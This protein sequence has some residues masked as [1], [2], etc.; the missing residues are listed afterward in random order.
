VLRAP[1]G[2]GSHTR[3]HGVAVHLR[4]PRGVAPQGLLQRTRG[5]RPRRHDSSPHFWPLRLSFL[6]YMYIFST[7]IARCKLGDEDHTARVPRHGVHVPRRG[8]HI[9]AVHL[10]ARRW[11][12]GRWR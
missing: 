1:H 4:T 9:G 11:R 7:V 12:G 8:V 5:G 6:F 10:L 2:G 3:L